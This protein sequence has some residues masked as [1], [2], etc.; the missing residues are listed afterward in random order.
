MKYAF[1]KKSGMGKGGI[2]EKL[3]TSLCDLFTICL[4]SKNVKTK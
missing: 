2:W 4:P 1:M 3:A